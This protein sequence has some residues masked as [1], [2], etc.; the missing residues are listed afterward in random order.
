MDFTRWGDGS[1]RK[2]FESNKH[3]HISSHD[4]FIKKQEVLIKG[5]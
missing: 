2:P 3:P 1:R 5:E 4:L